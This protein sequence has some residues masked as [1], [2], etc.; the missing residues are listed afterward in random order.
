MALVACLHYLEIAMRSS[1]KQVDYRETENDD[2]K[3][4]DAQLR[5][6]RSPPT[7]IARQPQIENVSRENEQR[8]RVFGIVVP[9][10][11][12]EPVNPDEA[13]R[14]ADGDGDESDQDTALAHAIEKVEGWQAPDHVADAVFVQE[15]LFSEIDEAEHTREA[16]GC[17]G[18]DAER[19]VKGEN[20]AGC[21]RGS[22]TVGR[23][24]L[25][26]EKKCQDKWKHER[27]DRPLAV[28]KF[29]AEVSERQ[30]PSE[31]R[32]RSGKIVVRHSVQAASA[33]EQCKIMGH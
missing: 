4:K 18:K 9:D 17:V 15:A 32:H 16:E 12:R 23:R 10:I 27:T 29:Q 13:H 20:D 2:S 21:G 1:E 22:K 31:K 28:K 30:E 5:R 25:R 7:G 3:I 8:D 26:E 19:N 11:A 24:E 6:A 14:G 33:V